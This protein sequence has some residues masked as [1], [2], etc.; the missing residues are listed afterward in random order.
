MT[1]E[2]M[3][4]QAGD[5]TRLPLYG[6]QIHW[7]LPGVALTEGE[8]KKLLVEAGLNPDVTPKVRG[9]TTAARTLRRLQQDT[10]GG[11]VTQCPAANGCTDYFIVLPSFDG[12]SGQLAFRTERVTYNPVDE[13]LTAE[14]PDRQ[15]AVD[16]T[17]ARFANCLLSTDIRAALTSIVESAGCVRFS[18]GVFIV[19]EPKLALVDQIETFVRSLGKRCRL[20]ILELGKTEQNRKTME[21]ASRDDILNELA[22][23]ADEITRLEESSIIA[24]GGDN[25]VRVNGYE[26]RFVEPLIAAK[27]VRRG[28]K[29]Q[30]LVGGAFM[31]FEIDRA[32]DDGTLT[33]AVPAQ[34]PISGSFTIERP[35]E[36]RV[37]A[38]TWTNK[39]K[40][41]QATSTKIEM[42]ADLLAYRVD[43][44]R[45]ILKEQAG[46]VQAHMLGTL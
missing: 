27:A 35:S 6:K 39:I 7:T 23:L 13:T 18:K 17:L 46:R 41:F 5:T 24:D 14:N 37:R 42:Y 22:Q 16:E 33:L 44:M 15:S 30:L 1:V 31:A 38:S 8:V 40:A 10:E 2:T 26:A 3:P 32:N 29:L 28:D 21:D 11:F 43:D 45:V 36:T 12:S 9:T 19:P 20:S 25:V 34:R 4:A